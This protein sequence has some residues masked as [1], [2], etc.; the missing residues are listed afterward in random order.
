MGPDAAKTAPRAHRVSIA[1]TRLAGAS[2]AFEA[3][4]R[5]EELTGTV[6][7]TFLVPKLSRLCARRTSVRSGAICLRDISLLQRV[8]S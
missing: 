7:H 2:R 4:T 5:R 8:R 3:H 1:K 6:R